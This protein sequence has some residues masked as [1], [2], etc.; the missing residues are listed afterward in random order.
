MSLNFI[1]DDA[2]E[3]LENT[4]QKYDLI[5]SS[6]KVHNFKWND[7]VD[8]F[9]NVYEK[10]NKNG[11]LFLLDKIYLDKSREIK[12]QME[13]LLKRYKKYVDKKLA[14]EIIF[15]AKQDFTKEYR[16]DERQIIKAFK[17][18]GFRDVKILDREV[19]EAVLIGSKF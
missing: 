19:S 15:H 12:K 16:M 1:C 2:L 4:G 9:K 14:K 8:L 7:K 18:I 5:F 13:I 10:L 3:F 17:K 6:W 11:K